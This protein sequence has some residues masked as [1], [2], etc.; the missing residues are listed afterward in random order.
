MKK[1]V[2][3]F[4]AFVFALSLSMSQASATHI[5]HDAMKRNLEET[6]DHRHHIMHHHN[7]HMTHHMHHK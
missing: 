4:G 6:K 7:H 5:V 3:A 2:L 1:L